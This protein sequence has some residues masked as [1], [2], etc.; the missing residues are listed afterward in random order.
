MGRTSRDADD[1]ADRLEALIREANGAAKDLRA[2]VRDARALIR[3]AAEEGFRTVFEK[4]AVPVLRAMGKNLDRFRDELYDQGTAVLAE[5]NRSQA[6]VSNS[7][8]VTL[9]KL[10]E[11]PNGGPQE[12]F[13][14]ALGEALGRSIAVA[15]RQSDIEEH[16]SRPRPMPRQ[17]AFTFGDVQVGTGIYPADALEASLKGGVVA[18]P[19]NHVEALKQAALARIAEAGGA[20]DSPRPDGQAP[21]AGGPQKKSAR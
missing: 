9:G 4:M 7:M 3:A 15:W 13:A 1:A 18:M 19:P 12:A 6:D 5:M 17:A 8:Y 16:R 21:P 11:D 10:I 20:E 14:T 2:E